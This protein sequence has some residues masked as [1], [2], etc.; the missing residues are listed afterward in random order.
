MKVLFLGWQN[1]IDNT[2]FPIGRLVHDG[3]FYYFVYL[4][5]AI[6]AKQKSN[7]QPIISFPDFYQC[8]KSTALPPLFQNRLLRPTRPDY[9]DFIQW[10]NLP[11]DEHNPIALLSRSGGRRQ[12]DT[13]EVFPV[14]EP[15]SQGNY[16]IHF[17]AHGIRHLQPEAQKYLYQL[18][19]GEKLN[20]MH[21]AQNPHDSRALMLRT[22]D[23]HLADY[24][25][26]YLVHDFFE[27]VTNTPNQV[28]VAI[29]RINPPP[30]PL[31]FRVLCSLTAKWDEHFHPF[32]SPAYVPLIE[33]P[34]GTIV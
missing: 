4:Q 26:R 34:T 6:E 9:P 15:D 16:R 20:L 30:T 5:G 33:I 1:P 12:T 21:D 7:F 32:S 25:P 3:D 11:K 22:E 2:W 19:S 17:F 23:L 8:Y 24:C 14:P 13:F 31:Q 18:R 27:L 29:E 10:L 28:T